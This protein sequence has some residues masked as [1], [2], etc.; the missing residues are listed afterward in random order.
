MRLWHREDVDLTVGIE[1]RLGQLVSIDCSNYGVQEKKNKI[2]VTHWL[3]KDTLILSRKVLRVKVTH[4]HRLLTSFL[5][6]RGSEG[7]LVSL[8][9]PLRIPAALLDERSQSSQELKRRSNENPLKGLKFI[10]VGRL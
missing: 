9:I 10:L 5:S 4:T 2:V 3:S 1:K 6:L 7:T 8:C